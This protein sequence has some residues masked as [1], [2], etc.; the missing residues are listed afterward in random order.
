MHYYPQ[1]C[2]AKQT[3]Q[4]NIYSFNVE[5]T[6]ILLTIVCALQCCILDNIFILA[7]VSQM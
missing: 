1:M 3:I 6:S 4:T 2:L 7:D 5:I